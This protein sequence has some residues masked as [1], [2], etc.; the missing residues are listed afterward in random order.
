M[1]ELS[2]RD[3]AAA[4]FWNGAELVLKHAHIT[5]IRQGRNKL[6]G[7]YNG[8]DVS[9]IHGT[10]GAPVVFFNHGT[11]RAGANC[12]VFNLLMDETGEDFNGVLQL[13]DDCLHYG[14]SVNDTKENKAYRDKQKLIKEYLPVCFDIMAESLKNN[15]NGEVAK[16]LKS[17]NLNADGRHFGE[18]T[19]ETLQLIEQRLK[20]DFPDTTPNSADAIAINTIKG[21]LN[22]TKTRIAQTYGLI[23]GLYENGFLKSIKSRYLNGDT[24]RKVAD[25]QAKAYNKEP[26][27]TPKYLNPSGLPLPSAYCEKLEQTADDEKPV[28]VCEGEIDA[29]TLIQRGYKNV[30]AF[31]GANLR[32]AALNLILR[33]GFKTIVYI[34]DADYKEVE[35]PDGTKTTK[36]DTHLIEGVSKYLRE[37][38]EGGNLALHYI[39]ILQLPGIADT[40][41]KTDINDVAKV[42]ADLLN[43][44]TFLLGETPLTFWQLEQATADPNAETNKAATFRKVVELYEQTPGDRAANFLKVVNDNPV[45]VRLGITAD[46]IAHEQ[47]RKNKLAELQTLKAIEQAAAKG[48]TAKVGDL[49]AKLSKLQTD[50]KTDDFSQQLKRAGADI[51]ADFRSRPQPQPTKWTLGLNS[52]GKYKPFQNIGLY[53]G[54]ISVICAQSSHCKTAFMFSMAYDMAMATGAEKRILYVSCEENQ[55]QL[56]E[57]FTNICLLKPEGVKL[58]DGDSGERLTIHELTPD[59]RAAIDGGKPYDSTHIIKGYGRKVINAYLTGQRNV[60]KEYDDN[61]KPHIWLYTE[62]AFSRLCELIEQAIKENV[63]PVWDNKIKFVY[64]MATAD[65]ICRHAEKFVEDT[66]Q[67]SGEVGAIFIDYFQLLRADESAEARTYELKD[68]CLR[69]KDFAAKTDTPIVVASQFN[70]EGLKGGGFDGANTGNIGESIDIERIARDL[71]LLWQIQKIDIQQYAPDTKTAKDGKCLI[72]DGTG[73]GFEADLMKIKRGKRSRLVFK[74]NKDKGKYER[75][76]NHLYIEQLKA[77]YGKTGVYGLMKTD[78]ERG[79]IGEVDRAN[80]GTDKL[81]TD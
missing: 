5:N 4:A 10:D 36:R 63:L 16:Y 67:N 72:D 40:G 73:E 59:E 49:N 25:D 23:V 2:N 58:G 3:K 35:Q 9:I 77:R 71:F 46:T 50:G 44:D 47:N 78:L 6:T 13:M 32:D 28:Y 34:A 15:P 43:P 41:K 18:L 81:K 38:D 12:D 80:S 45:L 33:Y 8:G 30:M 19:N 24:A 17:R 75:M 57:R 60:C 79:Y 26:Q 68:I 56:F 14:Y 69:L 64:S 74:F 20:K 7:V 61:G 31:S 51:L 54:D 65:E 21:S 11:G 66:K 27:A 29:I 42:N 55:Q 1:A 48:D 76:E 37:N 39:D 62:G 70:R 22:L 52:D 53:A